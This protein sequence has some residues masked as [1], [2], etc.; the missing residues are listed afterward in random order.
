M[1]LGIDIGTSGV[2]AVLL[3]G[4]D[5]KDGKD[6]VVAEANASLS[7]S[8]AHALWSEQDPEHWW[9]AT[10]EAIGRLREQHPASMSALRGVGLAGQMHGATLLDA[11]D[12]PLR[13]AILWN[14]GRSVAECIELEEAVPE[15]REITGNLAMPGFTAPKLLWVHRNE[16]EIFARLPSRPWIEPLG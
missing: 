16:P 14:D 9:R 6:E 12:R 5:G 13:P 4:L 15:A 3:D 10:N 7:V 1:Y 8:R 2:K 11:R